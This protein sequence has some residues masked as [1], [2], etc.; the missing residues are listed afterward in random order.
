MTG[1]TRKPQHSER[2]HCVGGRARA[3]TALAALVSALAIA[4][5]GCGGGKSQSSGGNIKQLVS[6]LQSAGYQVNRDRPITHE[7]EDNRGRHY[8]PKAAFT[9]FRPGTGVFVNLSL[10]S[11]PAFMRA[12]KEQGFRAVAVRGDRAYGLSSAG[13]G[14]PADLK[15][16][17]TTAEGG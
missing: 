16:V 3:A 6:R 7:I 11:D 12:F 1:L 5:A 2:F 15:K 13:G 17:V 4:T 10:S 9:I 8:T 14:G